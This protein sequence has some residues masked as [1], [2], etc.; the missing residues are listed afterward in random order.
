MCKAGAHS[1]N[2]IPPCVRTHILVNL[3]IRNNNQSLRHIFDRNSVFYGS[4]KNLEKSSLQISRITDTLSH[5]VI[6]FLL[7]SIIRINLNE[8]RMRSKG[9]IKVFKST[10]ITFSKVNCQTNRS[11]HRTAV[12]R[13]RYISHNNNVVFTLNIIG[14]CAPLLVS[15]RIGIRVITHI[16]LYKFV[17]EHG[18]SIY[19]RLTITQ[20]FLIVTKTN[21][22]MLCESTIIIS[23]SLRRN[24]FIINHV[25]LILTHISLNNI[26]MLTKQRKHLTIL[27]LIYIESAHCFKSK[28]TSL[29]GRSL[30][31][32]HPLSKQRTRFIFSHGEQITHK[33][34]R[35]I[36]PHIL[37]YRSTN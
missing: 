30:F 2:E 16:I 26:N 4:R 25:P 12:H 6:Y 9:H 20:G 8:R 37:L 21:R 5:A 1:I 32:R 36:L 14:E 33:S 28:L 24:S 13:A 3:H 35:N 27:T 31:R 10:L 22:V 11:F 29:F 18:S 17:R 15:K 7:K 19:L 23:H 34:A